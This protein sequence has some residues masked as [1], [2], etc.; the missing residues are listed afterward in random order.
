M[1]QPLK[2]L[3]IIIASFLMGC[4]ESAVHYDV[5]QTIIVEEDQSSVSLVDV[6]IV[7]TDGHSSEESYLS[8]LAIN[9]YYHDGFFEIFWL[10]YSNEPYTAEFLV[11]RSPDIYQATSVYSQSCEGPWDTRNG[12]GEISNQSCFYTPNLELQCGS[13][14]QPSTYIGNLIQHLPQRLY[15][16]VEVCEQYGEICEYDYRELVFE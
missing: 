4:H 10:T 15:F 14:D 8:P 13:L 6:E 16:F 5:H 2:L 3:P 12:C 7:D 11:G 9:P 1:Q